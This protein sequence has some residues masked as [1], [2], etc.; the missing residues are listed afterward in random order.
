MYI[1]MST[2]GEVSARSCCRIVSYSRYIAPCSIQPDSAII[3]NSIKLGPSSFSNV[4]V[5]D[6]GDQIERIFTHGRLYPFDIIEK[7]LD[8]CRSGPNFLGYFFHGK[9]CVSILTKNGL[10]TFWS[11]FRKLIWSPCFGPYQV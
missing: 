10:P 3:P 7:F 2:K 9:T 5:S 11:F 1:C 6:Q 4:R 8:N